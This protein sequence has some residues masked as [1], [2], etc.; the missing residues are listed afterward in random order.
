MNAIQIIAMEDM[1]NV[2]KNRDQKIVIG[3]VLDMLTD[4]DVREYALMN[5][6]QRHGY[7]RRYFEQMGLA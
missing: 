6:H 3:I 5:P 2:A 1:I 4:L 7:L